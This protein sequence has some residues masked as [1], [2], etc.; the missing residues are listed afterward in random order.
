MTG[1]LLEIPKAARYKTKTILQPESVRTLFNVDTTTYYGKRVYDPFIHAYRFAVLTGVRPGELLG[2]ERSDIY[3]NTIHLNKSIN[4]RGEITQGKNANAIRSVVLS[5]LALRV[6]NDQLYMDPDAKYV[7]DIPSTKYFRDRWIKYCNANGIERTSLYELRHTFVSI[8]KT[9]PEGMVKSIV[10]HSAQMDTFGIYGHVL[11]SD[12]ND[13]T[14]AL[15][16]R[17]D[18]IL[19]TQD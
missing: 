13:T 1:E 11:T 18:T 6:L 19:G 5:P 15:Q 3:G 16:D 14:K 12:A 17:F 2:I 9:L 4:I 10:G 8:A 7:F